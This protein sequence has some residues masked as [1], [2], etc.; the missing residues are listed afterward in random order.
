[1]EE[2]EAVGSVE[3]APAELA[4]A[5]AAVVVAAIPKE[6]A[7]TGVRRQWRRTPS[8]NRIHSR[9]GVKLLKPEAKKRA[10]LARPVGASE[11]QL[12]Q[13]PAARTLAR[14]KPHVIRCRQNKPKPQ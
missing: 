7:V 5:A 9:T 4:A 3:A 10:A 12:A 2:P 8:P 13:Q 6:N 11:R 14:S 1:M